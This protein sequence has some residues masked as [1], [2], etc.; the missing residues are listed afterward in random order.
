[1]NKLRQTAIRARISDI[2]TGK[3]VRKEG[4]EPSYVLSELGQRIS[5]AKL[6]GTVVDKFMSEDGNYSTITID[7]DSDSIRIK[8]FRENVNLLKD[9]ELGDLVMIIGKVREYAGENYIIPDIVKKVANPNYEC[10]HKLEILKE[11][12]KQR[13]VFDT[14]KKAKERF[15]DPEELKKYVEKENKS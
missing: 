7:D 5:R 13:K 3:F 1:M 2:T 4:L 14:I 10:L 6:L 15:G 8:A 11:L 12:L 9:I